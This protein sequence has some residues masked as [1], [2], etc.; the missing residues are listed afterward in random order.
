MAIASKIAQITSLNWR[1]LD[2]RVLQTLIRTSTK[3][4]LSAKE[5]ELLPNFN[6]TINSAIEILDIEHIRSHPLLDELLFLLCN[7]DHPGVF[8]APSKIISRPAPAASPSPT[9]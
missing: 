3:V 6:D 8:R 5:E 1:S 9:S 4:K 2:S 7:Q